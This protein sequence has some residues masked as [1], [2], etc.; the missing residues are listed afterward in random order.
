MS[1][2]NYNQELSKEFQKTDIKPDKQFSFLPTVLSIIGDLNGKTVLDLGCGD[3]FF[4]KALMKAGAKKVI[5][6]DNSE[7]QIG[8]AKESQTEKNIEYILGDIYKE[9]LPKADIILSPFV[10]NYAESIKDLE[11]LFKNIYHSLPHEGKVLLVI[12]LP[13]GKDIKK[14]GSIKTV[15]GELK[16]GV[17][18]KIDLY[19]QDEFLL[20][21]HS[22]YYTPETLVDVLGRA[23]FKSIQWHIA[24]I[25]KEGM[26][27]YGQDFWKDFA[28]NSELGYLSATK[29]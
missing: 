26:E 19:N 15:Q 18:I 12:D 13:K 23:G 5:G 14:F 6:I 21:L 22:N 8:L 20:T 10:V 25:S 3:G 1:L 9:E 28:D 4:T 17:R 27:K 24:R 11:F 2:N 29:I 16:D 7:T